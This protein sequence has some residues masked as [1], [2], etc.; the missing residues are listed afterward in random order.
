MKKILA[1]VLAVVMTMGLASV[2]FAAPAAGD[3]QLDGGL[4]VINTS[5]NFATPGDRVKQ[6]TKYYIALDVHNGT[7]FVDATANNLTAAQANKWNVALD[8]AVGADAVSGAAI[9]LVK[10]DGSY[11][12]VV[13]IATAAASTTKLEDVV[14]TLKLYTRSIRN[15]TAANTLVLNFRALGIEPTPY[16]GQDLTGANLVVSFTGR[17][18]EVLVFPSVGEFAIDVANQDKLY[19]GYNLT[20]NSEI[21]ALYDSANL[22]FVNF[23][24]KPAFNKWGVFYLYGDEGMYVYSIDAA[25]VMSEVDATYDE[26]YAAYKFAAK[27]LGTFILSDEALDVAL[28]NGV[29]EA[30]KENPSTGR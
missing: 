3:L 8:C 6:G 30:V 15:T 26:D 19:L 24:G 25:G 18:E 21:G 4:M 10:H 9:K 23:L 1:L 28:Y 29:D 12:W 2:A 13:E 16:A 14:G 5:G 27:R 11:Q 20:F 17:G 22:E 7:T